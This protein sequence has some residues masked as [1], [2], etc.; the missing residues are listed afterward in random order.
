MVK[1]E[2]EHLNRW[3]YKSG[4]AET[5]QDG[6]VVRLFQCFSLLSCLTSTDLL[7]SS[8]AEQS[9]RGQVL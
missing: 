5:G 4:S 2:Q 1:G 7:V 8:H 6:G 3:S 9:A